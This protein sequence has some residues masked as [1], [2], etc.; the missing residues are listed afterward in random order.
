MLIKLHSALDGMPLLVNFEDVSVVLTTN[1]IINGGSTIMMR[2][3]ISDIFVIEKPS[4][5]A[6]AISKKE[7]LPEFNQKIVGDLQIQ[8][9][10]SIF[11]KDSFYNIKFNNEI[12]Y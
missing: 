8:T 12:I 9:H 5:I 7:H 3:G 1:G 4:Q 11:G 6:A 10:E 2:N